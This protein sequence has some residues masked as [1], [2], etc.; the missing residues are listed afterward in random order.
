MTKSD[1][2]VIIPAYNEE[3]GIL[4]LIEGL[5]KYA[6]SL[7]KNRI[8]GLVYSDNGISID[9]Q[10]TTG[11]VLHGSVLGANISLA[12]NLVLDVK[13]D[14]ALLAS[15]PPGIDF[16]ELKEWREIFGQ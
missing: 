11:I 7:K 9:G 1:I 12:T 3:E 10:G 4:D 2:T 8:N 13:Y 14:H 15:P 16:F 6:N 5:K